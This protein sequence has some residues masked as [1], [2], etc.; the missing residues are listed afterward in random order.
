MDLWLE[1]EIM[2]TRLMKRVMTRVMTRV[3]WHSYI[4]ESPTEAFFTVR[5]QSEADSLL[6]DY[7]GS[8]CIWWIDYKSDIDHSLVAV[9]TLVL[10]SQEHWTFHLKSMEC[11]NFKIWHFNDKLH[12]RFDLRRK[13]LFYLRRKFLCFTC[14]ESFFDLRRKF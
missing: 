2:V 1:L 9:N 13:F 10:E 5:L 8:A 7:Q 12:S 11:E 4:P 14:R 6:N 3:T